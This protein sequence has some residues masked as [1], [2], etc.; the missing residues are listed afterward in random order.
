MIFKVE[1]SE[2]SFILFSGALAL[3]EK[4]LADGL[5]TIFYSRAEG[6]KRPLRG[7]TGRVHFFHLPAAGR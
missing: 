3:A 2:G 5:L 6:N 7:K 4:F 1:I